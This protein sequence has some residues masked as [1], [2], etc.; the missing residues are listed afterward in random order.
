MMTGRQG[1]LA[2]REEREEDEEEEEEREE[3]V[4]SEEEEEEREAA[5]PL[6]RLPTLQ[7]PTPHLMLN[8]WISFHQSHSIK[9]SQ[10][11]N[12][13]IRLRKRSS[14]RQKIS[15]CLL[16]SMNRHC[17]QP[18]S[19]PVAQPVLFAPQGALML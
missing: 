10:S 1:R 13:Q 2:G 15:E 6:A 17:T 7:P 8:L 5:A 3:E 16:S 9:M 14:R 12:L 11:D 4:E 18:P 19:S